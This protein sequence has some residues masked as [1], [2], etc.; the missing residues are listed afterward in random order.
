MKIS[1]VAFCICLLSAKLAYAGDVLPKHA[2][3]VIE[4]NDPEAYVEVVDSVSSKDDV[5]GPWTPQTLK[6]MMTHTVCITPCRIS[7]DS[8]KGYIIRSP[9][10]FDGRFSLT[11][12]GGTILHK[13]GWV[14]GDKL[15]VPL[16]VAGAVVGAVGALGFLAAVSPQK[17]GS[18]HKPEF[19]VPFAIT[20][21]VGVAT[22]LSGL[23]FY[24]LSRPSVKILHNARVTSR[25]GALAPHIGFSGTGFSGSF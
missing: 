19:A 10:G 16:I 6:I 14:F 7:L 12:S 5:R 4:S 21:G 17:P 15:V 1:L 22:M 13:K 8:E 18:P 2:P 25:V 24:L 20:A 9:N 3:V 11:N 23:A